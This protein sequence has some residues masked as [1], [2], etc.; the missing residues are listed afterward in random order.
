MATYMRIVVGGTTLPSPTSVNVTDEILWSSST[1]RSVSTGEMLGSAI[2]SKRTLD[3]EWQWLTEAEFN[4]IK[5]AMPKGFFG[6]VKY[7]DSTGVD[8]VNMTQAYRGNIQRED[9]GHHKNASGGYVHY[10]KSVKI[11]VI[12]K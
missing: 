1:G 8:V 5:N 6:A 2:A 10:Y 11:Q 7:Q 9:G 4:T 12:E 3:I